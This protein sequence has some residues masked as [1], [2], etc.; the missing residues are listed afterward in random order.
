MYCDRCERWFAHYRALEQHKI[1]S[2]NHNICDECDKD[3]ATWNGLEQHYVQSRRHHYCQA[4]D[5][6]FSSDNGFLNHSTSRHHFCGE[7][8]R[9]F[10]SAEGLRQHYIQ[11]DD[12]YYCTLC[13]MLFED[14]DEFLKHGDHYHYVCR[15]C[16]KIFSSAD[17]LANHYDCSHYY[18]R[19]CN[20]F[21][22]SA[23]NLASHRAS[24]IHTPRSVACPGRGCGKSFVSVSALI[25]HAESDTCASGIT[26]RA[27][28]AFVARLDRNNVIANPAR[29]ITGP[30]GASRFEE[31]PEY[32]ATERA[33]NGWAYEC[34]LCNGEFQTLRALDAHLK[35]QRHR[36][37]IY[38]C[39][40]SSCGN[41]YKALSALSQHI[42]SGSCGVKK[43]RQVQNVMNRLTSGMRSITV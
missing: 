33:W 42:E 8:R 28:D 10:P 2:A 22:Q 18:C 12:H 16:V 25:L 36:Q 14:E 9:M 29:M 17:G 13:S 39:P 4:C 40:M 34:F 7:H 43:N 31:E 37:S 24:S 3:F 20:R 35:S 19:E 32:W 38:R 41:E 1:D 21:F 11:S 26:R 30:N 27:I 6:H 5:R 15:S 23:A